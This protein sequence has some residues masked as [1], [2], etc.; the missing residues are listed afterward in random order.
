MHKL[1]NFYVPGHLLKP[2]REPNQLAAVSPTPIDNTPL[3]SSSS[4]SPWLGT[5]SSGKVNPTYKYTGV[6]ANIPQSC[7]IKNNLE[8]TR[9]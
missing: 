1:L 9:D 2:N 8:A 3:N 5:I 6:I 4:L 7:E